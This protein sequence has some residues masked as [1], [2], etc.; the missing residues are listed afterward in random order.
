MSGILPRTVRG[1]VVLLIVLAF[2][3]SAALS[4]YAF[5]EMEALTVDAS[6]QE[7]ARLADVT[8]ADFAG[9]VEEGR[10]M[11]LALAQNEEV[12]R[13]QRPACD[14]LLGRVLA[15]SPRYTALAVIDP[16]GYRVCG[17]VSLENPLYLGDR[18]YVLRATRTR[19]FAVGDYQVGRIT[20]KPTVGLAYPIYDDDGVLLSVLGT[21]LDLSMLADHASETGLPPDATYT[22]SDLSGNVLVRYPEGA[23]WIG[24]SLPEAFPARAAPE[25]PEGAEVARFVEAADLDGVDRTFA[26]VPL[27]R[28]GGRPVGYVTVGTPTSAL[29][30]R[31]SQLARTQ[32][33]LLGLAAVFLLLAAWALGHFSILN[34]AEAIMKAEDRIAH[35]D[36]SARTG[37][38][39]QD[40]ELGRLARKFDEMAEQLEAREKEHQDPAGV[41]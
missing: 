21:T 38:K 13:Y 1:R 32:V 29:A 24:Q 26:V 18:T 37:V 3:P 14:Q 36:L 8:A 17:A 25:E 34:R 12:G 4:W 41:G 10:A 23:E 35:G 15:A 2:I 16:D 7:L 27:E 40:D 5:R 22:L 39:H 6:Q 19:G 30:A 33:V 20:G 9:M 28:P 31:V 11:L